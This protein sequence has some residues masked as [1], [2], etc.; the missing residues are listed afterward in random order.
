MT[1]FHDYPAIFILVNKLS[2]S[3]MEYTTVIEIITNEDIFKC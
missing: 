1:L 2:N 3:E